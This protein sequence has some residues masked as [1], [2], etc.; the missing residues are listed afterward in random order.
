MELSKKKTDSWIPGS[1]LNPEPI[2]IKN[3]EFYGISISQGNRWNN[4]VHVPPKIRKY[5]FDRN[6]TYNIQKQM[7]DEE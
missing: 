3:A 6:K 7:Q 2:M 1:V 4:P 5:T